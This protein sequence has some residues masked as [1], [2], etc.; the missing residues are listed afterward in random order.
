MNK[1]ECYP[2]QF[3]ICKAY[4]DP[5]LTTFDNAKID[6]YGRAQWG[7]EKI[8]DKQPFTKGEGFRVSRDPF[9]VPL[10]CV[11]RDC[12]WCTR[13]Q[14]SGKY[15][16]NQTRFTQFENL[17]FLP[18]TIRRNDRIRA[19]YQR[20]TKLLHGKDWL[21]QSLPA[22]IQRISISPAREETDLTHLVWAYR[23]FAGA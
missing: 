21:E 11:K 6:V 20:E 5:H 3:S 15:W 1:Y 9:V 13:V 4:G 22:E 18:A 19:G 23:R 7:F 14:S 8:W 17:H 16:A 12:S 2:P 10:H